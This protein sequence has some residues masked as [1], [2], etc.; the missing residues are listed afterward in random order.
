FLCL[1][2]ASWAWAGQGVSIS[3]L[4]ADSDRFG[5]IFALPV[6]S[7]NDVTGQ[8]R[9][10]LPP[11]GVGDLSVEPVVR[12]SITDNDAAHPEFNVLGWGGSLGFGYLSAGN[13][14]R[15][16]EET[17]YYGQ[18]AGQQA[19][20][21][22][23]Y[24]FQ[25]V[26]DSGE[27]ENPTQAPFVNFIDSSLRRLSRNPEEAFGTGNFYL[28]EPSGRKITLAPAF[29]RQ[30][31]SRMDFLPVE[32]EGPDGR[33]LTITYLTDAHGALTPRMSFIQDEDG[34]RLRF[35]YKSDASSGTEKCGQG[36]IGGSAGDGGGLGPLE[37]IF[38]EAPDFE[39]TLATFEYRN[40]PTQHGIRPRL[41]KV[42]TPE[43]HETVLGFGID[44]STGYALDHVR[45]PEGGEIA[46]TWKP[47]ELE[48]G[49][50]WI[51]GSQKIKIPRVKR[52]ELLHAAPGVVGY[53]FSYRTFETQVNTN[54]RGQ[55]LEVAIDGP[56]GY[57]AVT[58]YH[59]MTTV[60]D[61]L[62]DDKWQVFFPFAGYPERRTESYGGRTREERWEYEPLLLWSTPFTPPAGDAPGGWHA[63]TALQHT[64]RTRRFSAQQDGVWLDTDFTYRFENSSVEVPA[65]ASKLD[66]AILQ[67]VLVERGPRDSS[68]AL[69]QSFEY[70][71]RVQRGHDPSAFIGHDE[72]VLP[73]PT[74][75]RQ[76]LRD[77]D[78]E[79]QTLRRTTTVYGDP[80]LPF[81]TR[82]RRWA[83]EQSFVETQRSYH[84]PTSAH[85]GHLAAESIG[86]VEHST[87]YLEYSFGEATR[88]VPPEGPAIERAVN[89]DG[90]LER[91][92]A[93]G[94]TKS[95]LYDADRRLIK[96]QL[97]LDE[98]LAVSYSAKVEGVPGDAESCWSNWA[99]QIQSTRRSRECFDAWGRLGR[100]E[101]DVEAGV[102][103]VTRLGY[104]DLGQPVR[105]QGPSGAV[106]ETQLDVWER[107]VRA[108]TYDDASAASQLQHRT[109]SY[110]RDAASGVSEVREQWKV[111]ED[112]ADEVV[113]ITSTDLADRLVSA[114]YG[115]A[116]LQTDFTYSSEPPNGLVKVR[117]RSH[118][119]PGGDCYCDQNGNC[120]SDRYRWLDWLGRTVKETHPEIGDTHLSYNSRG[121][122]AERFNV[123][124]GDLETER[125]RYTYDGLGRLV[126]EEARSGGEYRTVR[127]Y[128]FDPSN[129]QL[130]EA[131]SS[132]DSPQRAVRTRTRRFDDQQRPLAT[133][134]AIPLP[135]WPLDGL[136]PSGRFDASLP[137]RLRWFEHDA[138]SRY[139]V[140]LR[141]RDLDPVSFDSLVDQ[142]VI[143][144]VLFSGAVSSQLPSGSD[145]TA[146]LQDMAANPD[147]FLDSEARYQ[148]RARMLSR[149]H[150]PSPWSGWTNLSNGC[151]VES[152]EIEDGV[153]AGPLIQWRTADCDDGEHTVR[154]LVS[155]LECTAAPGCALD[156]GLF[157]AH[158]SNQ[159]YAHF[160]YLGYNYEDAQ[161]ANGHDPDYE[162]QY[163]GTKDC[164]PLAAA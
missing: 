124:P 129:N 17:Y 82:I 160:M 87:A 161:A 46:V 36:K 143:D 67:P 115:D 79:V 94:V 84:P 114:R 81:P 155:T 59:N 47:V 6:F 116:G 150:E 12:S 75:A 18:G 33:V 107:A 52:V 10:V 92:T 23:D 83:D 26:A 104:D 111:S 15:H 19:V 72:Y 30:G 29:W 74:G 142:L 51:N 1:A 127:Q 151:R 73:L 158:L 128:S 97:P 16:E 138:A 56:Q 121:L 77:K 101:M 149:E 55:W 95:F 20:F 41:W 35:Q 68:V 96:T 132:T 156:D 148:W 133:T 71:N 117:I 136:R 22:R 76:G 157:S 154:I 113:R 137:L 163:H 120:Y 60:W 5:T 37:C 61:D 164:A 69:V 152:F 119:S 13:P 109:F 78:G 123:G 70:T 9:A 141:R 153:D 57:R 4:Q 91:E 49:Y 88:I 63:R 14:D 45:L 140:Q 48:P 24:L 65:D 98:P 50:I 162:P 125:Y 118:C 126:K 131:T 86:G 64:V 66:G 34:R 105:S 103:G 39:Q 112:G 38:L 21:R 85:H 8:A 144:E 27:V 28:L 147:G 89:P 40:V 102:L 134:V 99:E 54:M 146:Y 122:L 100:T 130:G 139:R 11:I 106:I 32:I 53:D 3:P 2:A 80:D 42:V 7:Y 90:T 58:R 31:I 93:N 108:I 159:Q 145:R 44:H 135:Y 43:G 110:S 25:A 62:N